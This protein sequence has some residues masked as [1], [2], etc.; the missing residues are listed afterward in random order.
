MDF[1]AL[2]KFLEDK[3][4][5]VILGGW[6]GEREVSLRS[7]RRVLDSLLRQGFKA[8]G[9]DLKRE[10]LHL[11]RPGF[12]DVAVIM[13]HGRPGEDGTIQAIFELHGIPYT[14]SGVEAS[15]IGMDKITTKYILKAH[16]IRTPEYFFIP[17]WANLKEYGDKALE[18]LDIPCVV[19]PR[20]EGSS[21]GVQI[22]HTEK[23]FY[24][25]LKETRKKYGDLFVEK[26]IKGKTVTVGILGTGEESFP[27]PV[28]ELRVRGRE[29]YDY[30]AKYTKG[31]TEFIIPAE[32]SRQSTKELQE[33]ALLTHRV[34]G[35]KG[36]SRVDAVVDEDGNYYILEIN[37]IPGMTELSDLPKEA[38]AMGISYDEVV[39]YILRSTF[40]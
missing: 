10:K 18:K 27:L 22:C 38:E 29:F 8:E 5:T 39:L 36:F 24:S 33:A 1:S 34:I 32:I 12:T 26:Y 20:S 7:G 3:K 4:I 17:R 23:E 15:A 9:F 13:L 31:L 40:E 30:K 11:I 35:C 6:S 28:L 2:K 19:K 37:T 16:N 21:L 14:G 25:A